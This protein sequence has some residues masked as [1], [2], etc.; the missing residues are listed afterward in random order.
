MK[1]TAFIITVLQLVFNEFITYFAPDLLNSIFC[2][3]LAV[4]FPLDEIDAIKDIRAFAF[5]KSKTKAMI[6]QMSFLS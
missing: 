3:L 1:K 4:T 6:H 5:T 2:L